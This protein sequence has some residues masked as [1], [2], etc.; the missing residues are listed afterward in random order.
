M[1]QAKTYN[2]R[3]AELNQFGGLQW[4]SQ[5]LR[6]F[7]SSGP[8]FSWVQ[9]PDD[10]ALASFAS[11]GR[12]DLRLPFT[13]VNARF[14]NLIN[15]QTVHWPGAYECLLEVT[16]LLHDPEKFGKL[17]IYKFGRFAWVYGTPQGEFYGE[18]QYLTSFRTMFRVGKKAAVGIW[19]ALEPGV[20]VRAQIYRY[21]PWPLPQ[22]Q[23]N[24]VGAWIDQFVPANIDTISPT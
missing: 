5:D 7:N 13:G 1:F 24:G 6:T 19:L 14:D 8:G 10:M 4:T 22:Y 18:I 3:F 17:G 2:W 15:S 23:P 21:P 11:R 9:G 20:I 16:G 12:R